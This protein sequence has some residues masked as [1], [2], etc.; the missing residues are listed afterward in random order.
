MSHDHRLVEDARRLAA[1]FAP[2]GA[3]IEAARRLPDDIAQ[4]MGEAGFYR[5]YILERLGGLEAAPTVAARVFEALAQGDAACGWVAFIGATTGLALSRLPDEG[6]AEV[7]SRPDALVCG[8][9]A[10]N[11][12]ATRV[13]GGFRVTGKWQW[14]SGSTNA[15]WIGGGCVLMEDGEPLTNSAGAPRNHMLFFPR[16]DVIS[17]DTWHVAGLSGTGSTAFEVR[18]VFVPEQRASGYLVKTPPDRPL[19]RYPGF[20]ILANGIAAVGLGV[21]RASVTELV[22]VAGEKRRGG[23][24]L[25]DRPHTQMEVARAEARLR[26]AGA[27]F[28]NS[29]EAAW[30]AAQSGDPVAAFHT[31]DLRLATYHAM[32]ESAAVTAAMYTLAGGDSVYQTSALQRQFRDAHVATQHF[33]VSSNVLETAGRL[34]LGLP[35]NTAGF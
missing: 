1:E 9:F 32:T 22:R 25:A 5:M 16:A 23:A 12:V 6:A 30:A 29:I 33:M 27:F 15:D 13:A 17:L 34:Y 14:G 20:A 18:D 8:V 21:A 24:T 35:T 31:R 10:A 2:R 28:H 19:F 26:A 4:R 3:E 7:F 11:G